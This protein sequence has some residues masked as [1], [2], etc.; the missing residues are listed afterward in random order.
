MKL[1]TEY[2]NYMSALMFFIADKRP[3]LASNDSKI[4]SYF[5][6]LKNFKKGFDYYELVRLPNG[7]VNF[8]IVTMLG[9]K[10]KVQ[11]DSEFIN[12]DLSEEEWN[13][14]IYGLTMTHFYKEEYLALKK[15]Y[16][17]KGG[18]CFSIMVLGFFISSLL[19]LLINI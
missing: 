10:I 19:I 5:I 18:G 2:Q 15:G 17:K 7:M 1:Q 3:V 12:H 8:R 4:L 13:K 11:T 6:P 16:V 14:L 9:L